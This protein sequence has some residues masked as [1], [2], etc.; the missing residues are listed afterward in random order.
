LEKLGKIKGISHIRF[1]YMMKFFCKPKLA[2]P[3]LK[4]LRDVT[5]RR[6]YRGMIR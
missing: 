3:G 6:I 2:L 1:Q 4:I 5:R